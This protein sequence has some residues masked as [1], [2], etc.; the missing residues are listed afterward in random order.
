[1]KAHM[2]KRS[3]T[4]MLGVML[5]STGHAQVDFQLYQSATSLTSAAV[6]PGGLLSLDVVAL[7]IAGSAL[8][9]ANLDSFTYRITFENM[10]HSANQAFMLGGNSFVSPFDNAL[11]PAGF[12]GSVP[13]WSGTDLT[14]TLNADFGSPGATPLIADLYRTTATQTGTPVVGP[15]AILET[16]SVLAPATP[17]LYFIRLDVLEAAD[18]NGSFHMTSNGADFAVTV[19]PEPTATLWVAIGLTVL[20]VYRRRKRP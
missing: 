13:W 11:S 5:L 18:V 20:A 15:N 14:I 17:D 19:V 12:N 16:L 2:S 9:Q 10:D 4:L 8:T 6:A 1:M 3:E 7:S